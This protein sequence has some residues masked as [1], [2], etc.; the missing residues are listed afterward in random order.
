[1]AHNGFTIFSLNILSSTQ[2]DVYRVRG[3]SLIKFTYFD[4]CVVFLL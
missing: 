4:S 2:F 3:V 1:M